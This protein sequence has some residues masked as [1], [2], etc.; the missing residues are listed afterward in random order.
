MLKFGN[1]KQDQLEKIAK[2][3]RELEKKELELQEEREKTIMWK[4]KCEA[5]IGDVTMQHHHVN[6]QH[7][8]LQ[9]AVNQLQ[10][11]FDAVSSLGEKTFEHSNVLREKGKHLNEVH[12]LLIGEAE[13]CK[14]LVF[15]T[16]QSMNELSQ[17]LVKTTEQM[18][19]LGERSKEIEDIV[20]VIREIA[21]QTNLLSLNASIEAARAG[22]HGRGFA[23]VADEVRKLAEYTEES[24]ENIRNKTEVIESEIKQSLL[25]SQKSST[26]IENSKKKSQETT[27]MIETMAANTKKS[28]TEMEQLLQTTAEQQELSKYVRDN[29]EGA[30]KVFE[31]ANAVIQ[32]HIQD[33]EEVD[34]LLD[35][36]NSAMDE[37]T[38]ETAGV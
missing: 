20:Q 10:E 24:T 38:E 31:N 22:E 32:S 17:L 25:L 12:H 6:K 37:N 1:N 35:Q 16:D 13:E 15:V 26:L 18:N 3:E 11:K 36:L 4:N 34:V 2:L 21:A 30:N 7:Y 19:I 27:E 33:A 28:N 8:T 9:E 5:G 14:S 29:I 23:V